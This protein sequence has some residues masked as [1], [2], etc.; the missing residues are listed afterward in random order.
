ML[1]VLLSGIGLAAPAGLNA[2]IPLLVLALADRFSDTVQLDA[3]YDFVSS[4]WGIFALLIL[5]TIELIADKIPG[6]DHANDLLQTAIRPVVGAFLV[7][8]Q[9]ASSD[10]GD[11][12]PAISLFL[13]LLTAGTVHGA[14]TSIRPAV[15]VS[16]G[17][18]GNPI[19]STL[20]DVV[21]VVT[22]VIAIVLPLLLVLVLPFVAFGL[23]RF[24]RRLQRSG[25]ALRRLGGRV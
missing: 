23:W 19:V 6:V 22:S 3:P 16:T 10:V 2:Y 7:M 5:L 4:W 15:T 14:K 8:A 11:I 20:E 17:G 1:S 24:Y 25:T 21:A 18:V 9:S 12:N 13:G